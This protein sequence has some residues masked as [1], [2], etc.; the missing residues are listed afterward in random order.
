M[1]SIERD[2]ALEKRDGGGG[3]LI[4]QD[5]D[6]VQ[7]GRVVDRDL[8]GVPAGNAAADPGSVGLLS[9]AQAARPAGHAVSG[10]SRADPSQLLDVDVDQF[11]RTLTLIALRG[12]QAQ[13]PQAPLSMSAVIPKP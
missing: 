13:A 8:H 4:G 11:A 5:L 9:R 3:F 12:L 10:A 7:A 6:L 1:A 2:R